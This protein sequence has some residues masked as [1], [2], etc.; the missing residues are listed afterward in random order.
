MLVVGLTGS[1]GMGKSTAAAR[2]RQLGVDVFDADAEV[3][4]L[5][6]GP[7]AADIEREFPGTV[8]NGTVDRAKLSARLVAEPERFRDLEKIVHPRVRESERVFLQEEFARGAAVAVLEIPLLFETGADE[9]VDMIV[10]VSAGRDVQRQRVLVRPGMTEEK[11]NSLVGRQLSEDEKKA[12]SDFVVDTSGSIDSCH[13]QIDVIVS[14]LRAH[15]G[16]SY[17]RL[18][19]D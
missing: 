6:A 17:T 12:R 4:R 9:Q 1:I 5:Y 14:K 18:W 13:K 3:H 11:F 10:L 2:I 19:R 16:D 15:T 8:V 7:L